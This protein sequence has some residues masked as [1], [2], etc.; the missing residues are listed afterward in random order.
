M[1]IVPKY[2]FKWSKQ[3]KVSKK[4]AKVYNNPQLD[5]R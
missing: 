2:L 3:I 5:I 1:L 4:D